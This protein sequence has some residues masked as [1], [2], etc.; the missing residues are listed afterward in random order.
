MSD[1]FPHCDIQSTLAPAQ[2]HETKFKLHFFDLLHGFPPAVI[3]LANEKR[4]S[5]IKI[6]D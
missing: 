3:L 2:I 5:L 4:L 6:M 1:F